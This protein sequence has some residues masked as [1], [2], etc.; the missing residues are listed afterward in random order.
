MSV[1]DTQ[2]WNRSER[3]EGCIPRVSRG[4]SRDGG[5]LAA[6]FGPYAFVSMEETM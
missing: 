5:H 2:S 6:S 1:Q 3:D 4:H